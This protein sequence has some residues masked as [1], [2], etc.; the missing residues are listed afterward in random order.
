MNQE[1]RDEF[2]N[3]VAISPEQL[4]TELQSS[5]PPVLI[6]AREASVF[7]ISHLPNSIHWD[8]FENRT[9]E[10]LKSKR[11]LIVYCTI[12]YRSARTVQKL[13]KQGFDAY[14]LETGILGWM[15]LG[16]P[17]IDSK[18]LPTKK[19]HVYGKRWNLAPDSFETVW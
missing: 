1:I 7:S 8:D 13:R 14:N 10:F 18:K 16:G 19:D 2:P 9:Q 15:H 6:D 17:L 11:K 5:L 3:V 4:Q 12:G